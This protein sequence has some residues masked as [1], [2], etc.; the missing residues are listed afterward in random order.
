MYQGSFESCFWEDPT[1]TYFLVWCV[2]LCVEDLLFVLEDLLFC[3]VLTGYVLCMCWCMRACVL[4]VCVWSHVLTEIPSFIENWCL[5]FRSNSVESFNSLKIFV[6]CFS[7]M[8]QLQELR[9]NFNP[10][11]NVK[12]HRILLFNFK[13]FL[14]LIFFHVCVC[15]WGGVMIT[16]AHVNIIQYSK[17][18][19]FSGGI[20]LV[21]VLLWQI[22]EYCWFAPPEV[23]RVA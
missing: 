15:V 10:D 6:L 16:H 4:C 8:F 23:V 14:F 11:M 17:T 22:E 7:F 13:C 5:Q 3:V 19:T 20:I 21:I 18:E 12:V 1:V 2:F 9:E